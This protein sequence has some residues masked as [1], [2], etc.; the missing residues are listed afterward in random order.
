MILNILYWVINKLVK[1]EMKPINKD[2]IDEWMFISYEHPGFKDYLT[3]QYAQYT[4]YLIS[5]YR[6][7]E[8]Y[9]KIFAKLSELRKIEKDVKE[10]FDR[11]KKK[12]KNN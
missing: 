10:G 4:K 6:G 8:E 5:S 7:D 3:S 12:I 9:K 1:H 11:I 2:S